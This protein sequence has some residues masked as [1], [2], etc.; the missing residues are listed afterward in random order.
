MP[1]PNGTHSLEGSIASVASEVCREKRKCQLEELPKL[2]SKICLPKSEND[3]SLYRTY[4]L[5]LDSFKPPEHCYVD[6]SS[7]DSTSVF[8]A[9][10]PTWCEAGNVLT[11]KG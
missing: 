7:F 5:A 9:E 10:C 1:C 8:T 4:S 2:Y 6:A 3:K 11:S